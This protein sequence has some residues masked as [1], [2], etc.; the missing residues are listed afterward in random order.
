MRP[1]GNPR[2][3][4]GG[5]G[6]GPGSASIS[7]SALGGVP[8]EAREI[9][10]PAEAPPRGAPKGPRGPLGPLPGPP[11]KSL[12]FVNRYAKYTKL[13]FHGGGQGVEERVTL[14]HLAINNQMV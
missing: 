10:A 4:P 8:G 9:R 14:D 2:A 5:L 13:E 3:P 12:R 11:R 6:G 7:H 1:P